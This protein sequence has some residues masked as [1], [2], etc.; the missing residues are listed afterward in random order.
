MT[1]AGAVQ[2]MRPSSLRSIG[3][4]VAAAWSCGT[5]DTVPRASPS[6]VSTSSAPPRRASRASS[7]GVV[8]SGPI[9]VA[10]DSR[11]GPVS[12]PSSIIIVVTPVSVSPFTMAQWIGAA[13]R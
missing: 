5:G 9:G 10:R 12:R 3:A 2:S 13:P 6:M 7:S 8:S 1:S 4:C 11:M